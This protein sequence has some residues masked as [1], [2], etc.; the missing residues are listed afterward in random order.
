M[1]K[2]HS[3]AAFLFSITTL[4]AGCSSLQNLEQILNPLKLDIQTQNI[5]TKKISISCNKGDIQDYLDEGWTVDQTTEE[6]IICSWKSSKSSPGCNIN[7][8]KGCRI[9]VPAKTGKRIN[10]ILERKIN[11]NN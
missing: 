8:D 9:T 7:S 6:E 2:S 3:Y 5:E 10:Y 1:I 4:L 11:R